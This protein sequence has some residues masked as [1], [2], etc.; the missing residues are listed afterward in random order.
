MIRF[1]PPPLDVERVRRLLAS[2]AWL[3]RHRAL[4]APESQPVQRQET[5]VTKLCSIVFIGVLF[6]G[7][8]KDD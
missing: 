6:A 4:N 8:G 2:L 7:L 1:A 3:N 5:R